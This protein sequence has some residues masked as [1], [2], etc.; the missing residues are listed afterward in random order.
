ML[1]E[2]QRFENK[3]F[4]NSPLTAGDYE[5]CNFE[6][7]D[8]TNSNLSNYSFTDCLFNN[9]LFNLTKSGN[10]G[11]RNVIF[12]ECKIQGIHFEDCNP[13]LFSISFNKCVIRVSSFCKMDMRLVFFDHCI[14]NEIDFSESNLTSVKFDGCDLDRSV[15][16]NT[17]LEKS[18][19][20]TAFN[21]S[22]DPER[23]RLKKAKFSSMG[24]HGLLE[25][26]GLD[27]EF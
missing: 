19:F 18:D 6:H 12:K 1:F 11:F 22:I 13:F 23:N 5:E 14:L 8:F 26:Y 21:F 27:I 24:A 17:N 9:C 2:S 20:R 16:W 4:G 3:D 10:T 7:C 25:K 15:F